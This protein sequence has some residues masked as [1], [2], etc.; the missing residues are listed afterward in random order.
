MLDPR[1]TYHPDELKV[2]RGW[3]ALFGVGILTFG[4]LSICAMIAAWPDKKFLKQMALVLAYA[5]IAGSLAMG[6]IALTTPVGAGL[7]MLLS[8]PPLIVGLSI[9]AYAQNKIDKRVEAARRKA[10]AKTMHDAGGPDCIH[11][12]CG[13]PKTTPYM[14][15][16]EHLCSGCVSGR[17]PCGVCLKE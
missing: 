15:C 6:V 9:A 17:E 10:E 11:E 8:I 5:N 16:I 3:W 1:A 12:G 13:R 7:L 14:V 2:G 4:L